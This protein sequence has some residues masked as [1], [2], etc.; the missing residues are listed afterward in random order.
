[1]TTLWEHASKEEKQARERLLAGISDDL[2][3]EAV[4]SLDREG[5]ASLAYLVAAAR[6][7]H[8][9]TVACIVGS[10][11]VQL[12]DVDGPV[13]YSPAPGARGWWV[14][15]ADDGGREF[16][17]FYRAF[18]YAAGLAGVSLRRKR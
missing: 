9:T 2:G 15:D 13:I 3:R 4:R 14:S 11:Q 8:G 7:F 6:Q 12:V 10:G 16:G 18:R 1:M 17:S 5:T